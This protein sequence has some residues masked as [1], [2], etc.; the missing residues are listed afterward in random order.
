MDFYF[1][2]SVIIESKNKNKLELSFGSICSLNFE[3]LLKS[4]PL[5]MKA[6]NFY[7]LEC[8]NI[9]NPLKKKTTSIGFCQ[10]PQL[11]LSS[12]SNGDV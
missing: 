4:V 1:S 8:E 9:V 7:I 5:T 10:E 6:C 11:T 2:V 3:L 12:V